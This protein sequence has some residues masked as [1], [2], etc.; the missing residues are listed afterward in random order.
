MKIAF[1][2]GIG[3][4]RKKFDPDP[5]RIEECCTQEFDLSP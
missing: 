3:R 2:I 4:T 1:G 5:E